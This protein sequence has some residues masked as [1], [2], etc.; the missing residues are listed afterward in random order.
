MAIK[1]S[2]NHIE[3]MTEVPYK[4]ADT[5]TAVVYRWNTIPWEEGGSQDRLTSMENIIP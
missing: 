5:S 1:T 2:I 3:V 4:A